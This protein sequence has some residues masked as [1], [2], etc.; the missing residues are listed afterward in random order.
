MRSIGGVV[1]TRYGTLFGARPTGMLSLRDMVDIV[2]ALRFN[3]YTDAVLR[4]NPSVYLRALGS[5]SS[6]TAGVPIANY[7]R[8]RYSLHVDPGHI[9][10]NNKLFYPSNKVPGA[11]PYAGDNYGRIFYSLPSDVLAQHYGGN[12]V[13][14][15]FSVSVWVSTTA[16]VVSSPSLRH[17]IVYFGEIFFNS[18]GGVHVCTKIGTDQVADSKYLTI[19]TSG[20]LSNGTID[21]AQL[22][23]SWNNGDAHHYCVTYSGV[24]S[25]ILKVYFDG[26]LVV[27][28]ALT[29]NAFGLRTRK[30][31][32]GSTNVGIG[33][34]DGFSN[35]INTKWQDLAIFPSE[36]SASRV[37]AH[38]RAGM[39]LP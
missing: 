4:D 17:K 30:E 38:Y 7:A 28:A 1:G 22:P 25:N 13:Q 34:L 24:P 16:P 36:L 19:L 12:Y 3:K 33:V 5:S 35:D 21:S 27:D 9:E 6:P 39:L 20:D 15:P 31:S 18:Y 10:N 32:G 26:V 29:G 8:N 14:G 11:A 2:A 23:V 37:D